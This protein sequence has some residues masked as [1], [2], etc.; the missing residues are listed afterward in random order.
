MKHLECRVVDICNKQ[1]Y[2]SY[3]YMNSYR[4]LFDYFHLFKLQQCCYQNKTSDYF[5]VKFIL[6]LVSF[7]IR[8]LSMKSDYNFQETSRATVTKMYSNYCIHQGMVKH[9]LEYWKRRRKKSVKLFCVARVQCIFEYV[10][11]IQYSMSKIK[12]KNQ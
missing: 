2:S 3:H 4:V 7:L 12:I 8:L 11:N 1:K 10:I 6:L 5:I 9:Y